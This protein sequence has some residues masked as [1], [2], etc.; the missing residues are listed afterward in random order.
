MIYFNE[1]EFCDF[2]SEDQ[3]DQQCRFIFTAAFAHIYQRV[4]ILLEGTVYN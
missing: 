1:V 2:F 3:K 4:P